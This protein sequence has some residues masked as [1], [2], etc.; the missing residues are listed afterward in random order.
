MTD[1]VK[2]LGLKIDHQ[3]KSNCF[4][5]NSMQFKKV[6]KKF[7]EGNHFYSKRYAEWEFSTNEH[8]TINAGR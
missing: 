8:L 4:I 5:D 3:I 2:I 6:I 1:L 7:Y